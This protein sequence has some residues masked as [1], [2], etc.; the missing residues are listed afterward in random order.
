MGAG[1]TRWNFHRSDSSTAR[2][3]GAIDHFRFELTAV[4]VFYSKEEE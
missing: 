4:P 2:S 1:A 3:A